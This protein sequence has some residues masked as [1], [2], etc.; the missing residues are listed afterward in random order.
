MTGSLDYRAERIIW[1]GQKIIALFNNALKERVLK[2]AKVSVI[3]LNEQQPLHYIIIEGT[4]FSY[5]MHNVFEI[6]SREELIFYLQNLTLRP[7][8]FFLN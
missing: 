6:L 1:H 4:V 8:I 7:C 3:Q 2:P 5:G